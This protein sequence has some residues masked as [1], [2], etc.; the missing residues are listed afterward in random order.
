M[1]RKLS[2]ST[3]VLI[4][5]AALAVISLAG[6]ITLRTFHD[7]IPQPAVHTENTEVQ[8]YPDESLRLTVFDAE[9]IQELERYPK[10]KSL[11]LSGSTC[12]EEIE[13]YAAAHP[14]VDVVY[15]LPLPSAEGEKLVGNKETSVTVDSEGAAKLAEYSSFLRYVSEI[16]M[17]APCT[18]EQFSALC[19]GYHGADILFSITASLPEQDYRTAELDLSGAA[20]EELENITGFL[21]CMPG[22][23]HVDLTAADG[24][25]NLSL[26]QAAEI[27]ASA[28]GAEIDYRFDSFGNTVSINDSQIEYFGNKTGAVGDEGL[29]EIET[30]LP[31]LKQLKSLYFEYCDIDYDL[32][33]EFRE[34]HP[35]I[36]T[37]WRINFGAY[38]C[39][40]D[41]EMIFANGSLDTAKCYNLRYCN[42]VKYIDLGHNDGITSIDFVRYMPDLE[43]GI[44]AVGG[45]YDI[46]AISECKNLKY[47]E[48]FTTYVYDVSPIAACTELEHLN[49]S[50]IPASDITPLYSLT[51]LKRFWC[52][53]S[54]V[55][56]YQRNEIQELMPDCSFCFAYVEPTG[57]H[58]RFN[59]D[60][61]RVDEYEWISQIFGYDDWRDNITYW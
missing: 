43:V 30:M 34:A 24:S 21:P 49:I 2:T 57:N 4:V 37:V 56:Q 46:S 26:Q 5:V 40:T 20:P 1:K 33:A 58:W 22:L 6:Y 60:G 53:C 14:Q 31:C 42:K 16:H 12:Y 8:E 13:R 29:K 41:R 38:S 10:L 36:D 11:D 45:L 32:L 50:Y 35:E 48:I 51:K 7:D 52:T 15:T 9:G 47:L 61:S 17:T 39:R 19:S 54:N 18:P 27:S 23:K 25:N 3:A 44:F 59:D 55:P 28:A